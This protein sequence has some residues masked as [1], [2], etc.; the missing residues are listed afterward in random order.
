MSLYEATPESFF[1]DME[2]CDDVLVLF[3]QDDC[4]PCHEL[5][6]V[7]KT[8]PDHVM[9]YNMGT[10]PELPLEAK[11]VYPSTLVLYKDMRPIGKQFAKGYNLEQVIK[12]VNKRRELHEKL[13]T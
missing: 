13:S 3:Y 7:L 5:M 4:E 2:Y 11:V 1:S 10:D 12:W 6:Q 9:M 8:Y